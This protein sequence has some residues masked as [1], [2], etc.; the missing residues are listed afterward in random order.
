MWFNIPVA[1]ADFVEVQETSEQLVGVNLYQ[2][3]RHQFLPGVV[4][5]DAVYCIGVVVHN[6]VEVFLSSLLVEESLLHF[7]HIYMI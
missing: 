2:A 5:Y 6:H 7:Q 4:L 3:V 1:D